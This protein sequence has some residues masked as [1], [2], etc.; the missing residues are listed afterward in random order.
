MNQVSFD[1]EKPDASWPKKFHL[2]SEA[3]GKELLVLNAGSSSLKYALFSFCKSGSTSQLSKV[4]QITQA[5]STP[6]ASA[7]STTSSLLRSASGLIEINEQKDHRK[8][9]W[10]VLQQV[11]AEEVVA[12]GHRAAQS[13]SLVFGM[14]LYKTLGVS[15]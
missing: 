5:T 6:T 12:V 2:G 11:R 1:I 4:K 15:W 9:F 14:F 8:A 7:T 10:Q 3:M 13:W